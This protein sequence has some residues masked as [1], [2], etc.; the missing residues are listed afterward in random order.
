MNVNYEVLLYCIYITKSIGWKLYQY[1]TMFLCTLGKFIITY[2]SHIVVQ[3]QKKMFLYIF[4]FLALHDQV[5]M[6]S[7][8]LI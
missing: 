6:L 8:V 3:L 4:S 5:S 1:F 7:T 2:I